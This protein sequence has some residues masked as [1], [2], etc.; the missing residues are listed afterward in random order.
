M[1]GT[2]LAQISRRSCRFRAT[3]RVFHGRLPI[4]AVRDGEDTAMADQYLFMIVEPDWDSDAYVGNP[5]RIEAEFPEFASFE[6]RAEELG[7]RIVGGNALHHRRHGGIVKPG[8]EGRELDEA[9]W[10]DGASIESDE[11]ITG[12]Y[13]VEADEE[14]ARQLAVLIPTGGHIEWRKLFPFDGG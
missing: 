1:L 13:L 4:R 10:T 5:E 12:Y 7:A 8:P 9:V 2:G 6:R 14:V 11:V 3:A